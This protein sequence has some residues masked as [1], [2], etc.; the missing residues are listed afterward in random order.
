MIENSTI[1]LALHLKSLADFD[2]SPIMSSSELPNRDLK[3][4][5]ESQMPAKEYQPTAEKSTSSTAYRYLAAAAAFMV[6]GISFLVYLGREEVRLRQKQ[7][8]EIDLQPL[9][10]TETELEN[11]D[12]DGKVVVLYFWGFWNEP[13]REPYADFIK[14]QKEYRENKDCLVISVAC[15]QNDK[16]TLDQ[17]S[18]YTKKQF[19][20]MQW[21][22]LPVYTDFYQF[23]RTQVSRLFSSGGFQYPT[24]LVL[25]R[26]RRVEG[27]WRGSLKINEVR[28]AIEKALA[29]PA[30]E[31]AQK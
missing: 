10:Y 30:S 8:A 3:P 21:E 26:D 12:F 31:A 11:K 25:N 23:S 7:L 29:T 16:D 6:L 20:K 15:P 1:T 19:D 13:S 4:P 5:A 28:A 18:F 24:T 2:G 22:E 14:L 9:L 17:T 27:A